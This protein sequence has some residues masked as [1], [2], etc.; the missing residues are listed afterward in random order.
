[1]KITSKP[2]GRTPVEWTKRLESLRRNHDPN[3][4]HSR[5]SGSYRKHLGRWVNCQTGSVI[6]RQT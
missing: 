5:F 2:D 3:P 4:N 1:M 6:D